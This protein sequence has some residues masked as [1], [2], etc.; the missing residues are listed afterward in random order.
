MSRN[1]RPPDK[2]SG[3]RDIERWQQDVS[4]KLDNTTFTLD[5]AF[6]ALL[7]TTGTTQSQENEK[8][9]RYLARLVADNA[10]LR[11]MLAELTRRVVMLERA[12]EN[13]LRGKITELER[14][15][16][17]LEKIAWL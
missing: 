3:Q 2:R 4:Q 8:E 15:L 12:Q 14:K 1:L 10:P 11:G 13:S 5:D 17:Q 9:T 16:A 6:R 7:L